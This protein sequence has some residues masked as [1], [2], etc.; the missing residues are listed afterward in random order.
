VYNSAGTL[1]KKTANTFICY[2]R[3]L[4]NANNI[5]QKWAAK[6]S[7][8]N[9]SFILP[10]PT[11]TTQS[12]YDDI[13]SDVYNPITGHTEL[14]QTLNATYNGST[15]NLLSSITTNNSYS[16]SNYQLIKT[17]TKN[18]KDETIEKNIFYPQDYDIPSGMLATVRNMPNIPIAT[19]T[20]ITKSNGQQYQLT[21]SAAK[22]GLAPNGD[23]RP[24]Q[25]YSLQNSV[26]MPSTAFDAS[27]LIPAGY[28]LDGTTT[29]NTNGM[30]AQIDKGNN[31]ATVS[32]LYDYT[33]KAVIATAIGAS[34][35]DIAYTSFEGDGSGNFTFAGSPTINTQAFTGNKVYNLTNGSITKSSLNAGKAYLVTYWSTGIA[36]NV[37][38]TVAITL[39]SR[40]GWTLYQHIVNN[41]S[42]V[43]V[44]GMGVIDE[45]RLYSQ[46]AKLVTY[47][48]SPL[49]GKTSEDDANNSLAFYE[50][51]ALGRLTTL[52]DQDKNIIK[53]L[54]YDFAG[55]QSSC[56]V[57]T[58]LIP[59]YGTFTSVCTIPLVGSTVTYTV[60]AGIY[61]TMISQKA[62]EQLAIDDVNANGQ[63]YANRTG[64]CVADPSIP[65]ILNNSYSGQ[66]YYYGFII[67]F[68]S[69]I[70]GHI[71]SFNAN[72]TNPQPQQANI[73]PGLYD[74]TIQQSGGMAGTSYQWYFN[75]FSGQS[76]GQAINTVTGISITA[77]GSSLHISN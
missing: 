14:T 11:A 64:K 22:F 67:N 50:Y 28:M 10:L 61:R 37:N 45:L 1:I 73:L 68:I 33:N 19:R 25:M 58:N 32:N 51:D 18:S 2:K 4:S 70:D 12:Q 43:T 65:V 60:P 16:Q 26:P 72:P 77:A 57:F 3:I 6:R 46:G 8:Y 59:H 13:V 7:E 56:T 69:K 31:V 24:L 62:A 47:T 63:A 52:R 76:G 39:V 35:N 55:Y 66:G 42:T 27:Q 75:Q 34:V 38:N 49:I 44:S 23:V 53:Q 20:L 30:V 15:G 71:Y 74:I 48:Y 29:Y 17:T 9:G 41:A 5:S 54:C 40:N 21:G 36:A